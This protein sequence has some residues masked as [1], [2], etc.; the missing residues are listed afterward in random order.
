MIVFLHII[1]LESGWMNEKLPKDNIF[2]T[3]L[4]WSIY[5]LKLSTYYDI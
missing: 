3:Y 2:V 5:N 1:D 4:Y